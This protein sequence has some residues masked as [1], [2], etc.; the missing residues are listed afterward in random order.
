SNVAR[1]AD[2]AG[3]S[4]YVER[5]TSELAAAAWNRFQEIERAGGFVAAL[6][7]GDV[8]ARIAATREARERAIARRTRSL[9]GL[10]EFPN[11]D[12]PLPPPAPA[13]GVQAEGARFAPLA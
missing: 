6:D 11:I 8:S 12:E 13:S 10:S 2:P 9:T 4:W 3:G 7:S 5:L 1:V